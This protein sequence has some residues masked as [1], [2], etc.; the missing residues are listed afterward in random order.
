MF[1]KKMAVRL[2]ALT[3]VASINGFAATPVPAVTHEL[4]WLG[5]P[6]PNPNPNPLSVG[7]F[8]PMAP[9]PFLPNLTTSLYNWFMGDSMP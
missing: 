2:L 7:P 4:I 5:T 9:P 8:T 1:L 6:N 3:M